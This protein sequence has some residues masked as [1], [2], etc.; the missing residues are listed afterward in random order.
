M[1][2]L[3]PKRRPKRSRLFLCRAQTPSKSASLI[4]STDPA[5][6]SPASTFWRQKR[7]Q[8]VLSY[9]SN[10]CLRPR[11]LV[12]SET[13]T[14]EVEIAARA[15]GVRLLFANASGPSEIAAAFAEFVQQRP[16]ALQVSSD[17]LLLT[18]P[19]Q[20]VALA[21]RYAI[22]TI[23]AWPQYAAVGGLISYGTNIRA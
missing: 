17:G 10:W 4:A 1:G 19:D 9:C 2:R 21:D 14:R 23:Y 3:Q 7:R 6:I 22:P 16:D 11:R 15:H 12:T 20:I 18:Y 13:E 8:N 5:A